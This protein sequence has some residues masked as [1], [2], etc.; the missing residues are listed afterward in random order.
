MRV[1]TK[2]IVSS[3]SPPESPY[4][5]AVKADGLIFLGHRLP[6]SAGDLVRSMAPACAPVVSPDWATV[7]AERDAV[8]DEYQQVFGG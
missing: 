4:S 6:K 7:A 8:L 3:G 2:E 1:H 5:V